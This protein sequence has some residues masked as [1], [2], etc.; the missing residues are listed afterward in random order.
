MVQLLRL[1]RAKREKT[2]SLLRNVSAQC[3]SEKCGMSP[4]GAILVREH[5]HCITTIAAP[6]DACRGNATRLIF[7]S[8]N[9]CCMTSPFCAM[10]YQD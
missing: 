6:G 9:L 10:D 4:K 3:S 8:K 1:G 2:A 5:P 7:S